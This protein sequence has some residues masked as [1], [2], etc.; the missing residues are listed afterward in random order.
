MGATRLKEAELNAFLHAGY[1]RSVV[2]FPDRIALVVGDESLTYR[3][4]HDRAA[5]IAARLD[6][7]TAA[8]PPLTAVYGH[9]STTAFVGVLA[10]LLRGHGYVPLNRTFPPART[11]RMLQSAGC[12]TVIVD[13]QSTNQL[14]EVL[15]GCDDVEVLVFPDLADVDELSHRFAGR[16]VIGAADLR[17]T[18]D[19]EVVAPAADSI[20][21]LLFTS[22]STG[23]PKGVMVSHSNAEAFI[24]WAVHHYEVTAEDRVS[25]TFDLTFDLSVFD[26]FVAWSR[27]AR[28]CCPSQKAII[29]PGRFIREHELTIWF[30]VPSTGAFM[31][32]LGALKPDSYPSLR[33]SLFCGEP[34]P[35]EVAS[36]WQTAAPNAVV[37]N[38]YGPTETTI[39]CTVYRWNPAS[40]PAECVNGIVPIGEPISRMTAI[41][42]DERLQEVAP[43]DAGELLVAGPQVSLGYWRDPNK[44]VASFVQPANQE[45]I[46]YRTG[47]RVKRVDAASPLVYLGR[48]DHQIKILGHRVEL[49]EIE[50]VIRQESDEDSVVAIGWPITPS[51]AGGVVAFVGNS[52]L[53]GD[54]ILQR[55]ARRLPDYMVPRKII[56]RNGLPTNANGK[57]DRQALLLDL[58]GTD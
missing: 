20:A 5:A 16:R 15:D 38:L 31:R 40:S 29:N 11:S 14:A 47:D 25:Q 4:L 10:A 3:E 32:R 6:G 46:H 19:F 1:L 18:T 17:E 33:W 39:A 48:V 27:G 37:E 45:V 55:V 13:E 8:D 28:L 57:V 21:Y 41:V 53:D 56:V 51:G 36:A 52:A 58:K 23:V 7:T 44:T 35:S 22:G 2:A 12:R 42:A 26:M 50:A 49:G 30:S 34:L 9:R 43:G 24:D 54:A